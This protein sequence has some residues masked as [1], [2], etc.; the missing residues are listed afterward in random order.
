MAREH[1]QQ[2]LENEGTSFYK[3][4]H[5]WQP[6]NLIPDPYRRNLL[7]DAQERFNRL[8]EAEDEMKGLIRGPLYLQIL[9]RMRLT[10]RQAQF[11]WRTDDLKFLTKIS[12]FFSDYGV[13]LQ[14]LKIDQARGR[15]EQK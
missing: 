14:N 15:L 3:V 5:R 8:S 11:A 9:Y 13:V 2:I 6:K 10:I 1:L 7:K 12:D 4:Y